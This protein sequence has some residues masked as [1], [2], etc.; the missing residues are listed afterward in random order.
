MFAVAL[1][2]GLRVFFELRSVDFDLFLQA[3][4][5]LCDNGILSRRDLR[6]CLSGF[7]RLRFRTRGFQFSQIRSELGNRSPQAVKLSGVFIESS[8]QL[9]ALLAGA[10]G[11]GA[12][13]FSRLS[14]AAEQFLDFRIR[15][16]RSLNARGAVRFAF[17]VCASGRDRN[18]Q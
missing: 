8:L 18:K 17:P 5:P 2:F 14:G 1:D 16:S 7:G 4:E 15:W 6:Q 10:A 13:F 3:V 12:G 11:F 9:L